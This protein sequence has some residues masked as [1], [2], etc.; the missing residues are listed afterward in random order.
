MLLVLLVLYLLLVRSTRGMGIA[1]WLIWVK[2]WQRRDVREALILFIVHLILNA[3]WSIFF[4]GW[5]MIGLALIDIIVILLFIIVLMW[6][7]WS[8]DRRA[9]YLFIPYLLWV[10]FATVLN[11]AIWILN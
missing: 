6:K 7:F 5:H 4:F 8:I 10:S 2:G 1:A 9:T 11:F 3:L